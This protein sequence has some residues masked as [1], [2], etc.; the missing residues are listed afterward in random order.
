MLS[1]KFVTSHFDLLVS[2]HYTL[3]DNDFITEIAFYLLKEISTPL[4]SIAIIKIEVEQR[5][6]ISYYMYDTNKH[7]QHISIQVLTANFNIC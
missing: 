6:Q 1:D 2:L 7:L 3:T 4:I 5:S